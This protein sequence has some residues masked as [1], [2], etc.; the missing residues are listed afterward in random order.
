M[1][2]GHQAE[3]NKAKNGISGRGNHY[4]LADSPTGP[5]ELPTGPALDIGSER[6]AA[7]IVDHGGLKIIG[8]KDGEPG[9][10]GGYIMD[11]EPVSVDQDGKLHLGG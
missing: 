10:F 7:R 5:W 9:R 11:P 3:W 1:T 2:S 6:Y 4:L 8:F